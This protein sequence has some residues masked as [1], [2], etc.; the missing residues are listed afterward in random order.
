LGWLLG[1]Q[2][3]ACIVDVLEY[4]VRAKRSAFEPQ[5]SEDL[6]YRARRCCLGDARVRR[7]L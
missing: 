5:I 1:N 6:F 7:R 4:G 3:Y 2:L